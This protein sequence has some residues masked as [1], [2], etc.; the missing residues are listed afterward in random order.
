[1]V[2]AILTAGLSVAPVHAATITVGGDS[3]TS[4]DILW[5]QMVGDTEL[6]ALGL[7]NVNVTDTYTDFV[8]TLTNST[9]LFNERVH[10]LGFDTNP[11]ATSL[12]NEVDGAY[13]GGFGLNTTFPGFQRIDVCA[14][15][16]GRCTGGAQGEN[17]PGLG[18]SDTFGFRLNGD[19]D[20]GIVIS[21]FALQF[22]GDLGSFQ[23]EGERPPAS[24]PEPGS[25]LLLGL[26]ITVSAVSMRR[27]V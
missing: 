25:L 19:F 18:A 3:S 1:M 26:G 9:A 23:F 15:T 24:V 10:S 6:R 22:M 21:R 27:R 14:W 5:S 20:E 17:L 4:F 2:T 7:F 16:D 12:T 13:F 8:I 11:N